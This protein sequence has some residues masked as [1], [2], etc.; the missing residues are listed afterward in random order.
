MKNISILQRIFILAALAIAVM[1]GALVYSTYKGTNGIVAERKAMLI[2][3]NEVA[4]SVLNRYHG[5]ETAGTMTKAEAQKA[6][7]TEIMAMRYG[8]YGYFWINDYEG[9]MLAHPNPKLVGINRSNIPDK[10]GKY[11]TREFTELAKGPGSGFVD[12]FTTKPG[13]M[14]EVQKY[15]HVIGFAPWNWVVGN[16]VYGD[17]IV[18]IQSANAIEAGLVIGLALIIN[19]GC[20]IFVGRSISNP[21]NHLKTVMGKIAANDTTEEVPHT[22]RRD[23]IGHIADALVLIRNSVI[24]RNALEHAKAEQQSQIDASRTASV[25]AER[26]N[27]EQQEAVVSRFGQVFEA[28]SR[29]DLTVRIDNLP[30]EYTKLGVDFNE[31]IGTLREAMV[32]ISTSTETVANSIEEINAAVGQ[33]S[34]RTESQAASLEQTSAAIAEIGKTI[35]DSDTNISQ[36]RSMAGEAKKDAAASSGIVGKAIDAMGRIEESSSKINE[37][38]GVIDD[39]AFQTNLL[40]LNAGVEAARAG[41]AGKG[42]AVVAQEVRELAQRSATAAK[43]IKNLIHASATQVGAGVELVEATGK[44]L[45][46][47]DGRVI[48]INDSIAAVAALA[49]EQSA[50]IQQIST[51]INQIDQSTQHN[52]AMVEETTAATTTLAS[53]AGQLTQLL[54]LFKVSQPTGYNSYQVNRAHAA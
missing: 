22:G 47:I 43:E 26:R 21:I 25:E 1:T 17:D 23:E 53:E 45:S 37:I 31:A 49:Q 32:K 41:E 10:N 9:M 38:I 16:G 29:G 19:I 33:L 44:A 39:I 15:S 27:R 48:S 51:A 40:A 4:I 14:E 11:Q 2:S 24:E 13:E 5:L 52:A 12:Y 34:S 50:S 46:G 18:T 3:M 7:M 6:A 28:L 42:F 30:G 35:R 8:K 20:A 36:A 54:S